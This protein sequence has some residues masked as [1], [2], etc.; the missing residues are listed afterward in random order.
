VEDDENVAALAT[1]MVKQLG[2]EV[3]RV[4]SPAAAL[5]ALADGRVID[6]V[7][8]DIVMPGGMNG[9][10][11]AREIRRRRPGVPVVLTTGYSGGVE[12][13]AEEGIPVLRKPY[14][15]N[16]LA[17]TFREAVAGRQGATAD[18]LPE[19]AQALTAPL[20]MSAMT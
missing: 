6:I 17:K 8:S 7:F 15:L 5:G 12:A 14:E 20:T 1:E 11:L 16:E 19:A 13:D 18:D 2:Y 4:G 9:L 3:I 10:D